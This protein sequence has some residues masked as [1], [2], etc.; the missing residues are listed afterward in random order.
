[1]FGIFCGLSRILETVV[2]FCE[3]ECFHEGDEMPLV[4]LLCCLLSYLGLLHLL[5]KRVCET[6]TAS[7]KFLP[8][9]CDALIV[10]LLHV[11]VVLPSGLEVGQCLGEVSQSR[12]YVVILPGGPVTVVPEDFFLQLR[13]VLRNLLHGPI[14]V[15]HLIGQVPS[16]LI[17]L[18]PKS[19]DTGLITLLIIHDI[20]EVSIDA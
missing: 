6:V 14:F 10:P 20:E 12:P 8:Q 4:Q 11:Y 15:L 7:L 1:M 2:E 17:Q 13:H 16:S 3:E 5:L 19:P 9:I 18:C